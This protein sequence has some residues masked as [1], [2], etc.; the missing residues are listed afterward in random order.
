MAEKLLKSVVRDG[1][2]IRIHLTDGVTEFLSVDNFKV[3]AL[4]AAE[5]D[6]IMAEICADIVA[7]YPGLPGGPGGLGDIQNRRY[8]R[9]PMGKQ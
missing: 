6:H 1:D 8:T 2:E 7:Q 5:H 3:R 9:K 4:K